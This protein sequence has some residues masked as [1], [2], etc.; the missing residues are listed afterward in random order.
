MKKPLLFIILLL[1]FLLLAQMQ[2]LDE[3]GH[4]YVRYSHARVQ[5]KFMT[6]TEQEIFNYVD[7]DWVEG[8][9]SN[10]FNR[11][12]SKVYENWTRVNMNDYPDLRHGL[13]Y[14]AQLKSKGWRVTDTN[15]STSVLLSGGGEN[16]INS[17]EVIS[18]DYALSRPSGQTSVAYQ[19]PPEPTVLRAVTLSDEF[20]ETFRYS[21]LEREENLA[22]ERKLLRTLNIKKELNGD[23]IEWDESPA[24]VANYLPGTDRADPFVDMRVE[25]NALVLVHSFPG[26]VLT[27]YQHYF[28][29][30]RKGG[31]M[32]LERVEIQ[33]ELMYKGCPR[34]E[35]LQVLPRKSLVTGEVTYANCDDDRL[36]NGRKNVNQISGGYHKVTVDGFSLRSREI[37]L[38]R[39]KV[40]IAY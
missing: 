1:P 9:D 28:E 39:G 4:L 2:Q 26:E 40:V 5:I 7:K 6:A 38:E 35:R 31:S 19:P 37:K 20:G 10:P 32:L 25:N 27:E 18:Y 22:G 12:R 15:M 34:S 29:H 21:V 24:A 23:W 3:I 16:S 11:S 8:D 14:L 30:N 17:W 13:R 36:S 33:R